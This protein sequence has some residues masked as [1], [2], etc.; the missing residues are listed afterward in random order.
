MVQ[1]DFRSDLTT[2]KKKNNKL[3]KFIYYFI[4]VIL[5]CFIFVFVSS[6]QF[7]GISN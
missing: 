2:P 4:Y 5:L 6:A 3:R 1:R 7:Y